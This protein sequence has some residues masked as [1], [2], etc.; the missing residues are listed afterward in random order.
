MTIQTISLWGIKIIGACALV[1]ALGMLSL[2][3][4]LSFLGDRDIIDENHFK[5]RPR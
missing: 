2:H 5:E 3:A 1:F 4:L